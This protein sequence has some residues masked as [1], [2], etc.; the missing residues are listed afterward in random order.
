MRRFDQQVAKRCRRA[1]L[2]GQPEHDVIALE[3]VD[4]RTDDLAVRQRLDRFGDRRG[5]TP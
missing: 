3:A 1:F 4:D 2:V 5:A